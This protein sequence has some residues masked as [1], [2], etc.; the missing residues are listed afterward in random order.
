L[1]SATTRSLRMTLS[2][3]IWQVAGPDGHCGTKTMR[4]QRGDLRYDAPQS[5][6]AGVVHRLTSS[7][8]WKI[9]TTPSAAN[10]RRTPLR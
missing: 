4:R 2:P 9:S 7:P 6:I 8:K 3:S 5:A 10:S 1:L